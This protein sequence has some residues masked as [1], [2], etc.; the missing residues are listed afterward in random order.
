MYPSLE[1]IISFLAIFLIVSVLVFGF[2]SDALFI[3][4]PKLVSDQLQLFPSFAYSYYGAA[5]I[6]SQ[7][8]EFNLYLLKIVIKIK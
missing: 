6:C 7:S 2:I 1:H 4:L 8:S 3:P 5:R